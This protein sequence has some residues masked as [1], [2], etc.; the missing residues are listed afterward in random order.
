MNGRRYQPTLIRG[1]YLVQLPSSSGSS[2]CVSVYGGDVL[3]GSSNTDGSAGGF[4]LPVG[5]CEWSASAFY[6][7]QQVGSHQSQSYTARSKVVPIGA[8]GAPLLNPA[9]NSTDWICGGSCGP[10]PSVKVETAAA[11]GD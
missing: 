4:T 3:T 1:S 5:A 2:S 7:P 8:A 10:T 9:V 6:N 11:P